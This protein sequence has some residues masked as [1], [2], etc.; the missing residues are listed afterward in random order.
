MYF[1][2]HVMQK[3]MMRLV[4]TEDIQ[5]LHMHLPGKMC[6]VIVFMCGSGH[7]RHFERKTGRKRNRQSIVYH[8]PPLFEW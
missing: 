2:I 6:N 8:L 5:R 1:D 3:T 7:V 4:W